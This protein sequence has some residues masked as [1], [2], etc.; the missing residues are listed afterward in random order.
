MVENETEG[1]HDKTTDDD[2]SVAREVAINDEKRIF[3]IIG[4]R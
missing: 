4:D 2:R 3:E 1:D